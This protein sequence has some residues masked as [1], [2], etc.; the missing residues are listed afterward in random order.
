M[1]QSPLDTMDLCYLVVITPYALCYGYLIFIMSYTYKGQ[2][3]ST[4]G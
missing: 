3:E 4:R 2:H 1:L